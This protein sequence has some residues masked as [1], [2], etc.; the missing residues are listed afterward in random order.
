MEAFLRSTP[1]K[2]R[3]R[4]LYATDGLNLRPSAVLPTRLYDC[5]ERTTEVSNTVAVAMQ[6]EGSGPTDLLRQGLRW[7]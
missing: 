1:Q 7:Y 6:K 2:K 4:N 5:H 3:E